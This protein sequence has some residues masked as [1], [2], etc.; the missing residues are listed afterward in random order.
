MVFT[1]NIPSYEA[2]ICILGVAS[3][4]VARKHYSGM[5]VIVS[6]IAREY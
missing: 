5:T 1:D 6:R 2:M 3:S 4:S